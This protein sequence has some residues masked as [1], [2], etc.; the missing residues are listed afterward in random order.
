MTSRRT[1]FYLVMAFLFLSIFLTRPC[2]ADS[3]GTVRFEQ[4]Y[5]LVIVKVW[6]DGKGPMDFVFDTGATQTVILPKAA[7]RIGL[8]GQPV[9]LGGP[10]AGMRGEAAYCKFKVGSVEVE[11]FMV[12]ITDIPSVTAQ[13]SHAGVDCEGVVGY[14][15]VSQFVVTIDYGQKQITLKKGSKEAAEPGAPAPSGYLGVYVGELTEKAKKKTELEEGALIEKVIPKSPA[16]KERLKKGDV[17]V[18]IGDK[19]IRNPADARAALAALRPESEVTITY[20]RYKKEKSVT[21]KLGEH[22]L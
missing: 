22:P 6:A 5:N 21:V 11:N 18:K 12:V 8:K 7:E 20:R 2:R 13:L 3:E 19:P 14:T 1:T 15:F 9:A 17:I 16:S 10:M 4:K